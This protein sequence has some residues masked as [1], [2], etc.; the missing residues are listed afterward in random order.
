MTWLSFSTLTSAP[1]RSLFNSL[2][3]LHFPHPLLRKTAK[4][5]RYL[6]PELSK[7]IA[8]LKKLVIE[9][10][11]LGMALPQIGVSR[12]VIAIRL[13]EAPEIFL[14]PKIKSWEGKEVGTE[15]CLSF[16]GSIAEIE[17]FSTVTVQ[18][19]REDGKPITLTAT[20]LQ[21]RVF[22][23]EIDHLDGILIVDRALPGSFRKASLQEQELL[24]AIG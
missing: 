14:N 23:H 17:R 24:A 5:V 3:V 20:G 15:G 4:R 11:G 6:T 21:A 13:G 1:T 10:E 16:P 2:P 22:Q 18:A 7:A 12:R 9:E 19:Q 8:E